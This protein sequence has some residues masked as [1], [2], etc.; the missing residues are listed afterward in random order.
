M[1]NCSSNITKPVC[2]S[3]IFQRKCS[4]H[5]VQRSQTDW[6]GLS[7]TA[8]R[9]P[10]VSCAPLDSSQHRDPNQEHFLVFASYLDELILMFFFIINQL[11][12]KMNQ[13]ELPRLSKLH[14]K[15]L[16]QIFSSLSNIQTDGWLFEFVWP[17]NTQQLKGEPHFPWCP[18]ESGHSNKGWNREGPNLP[19]QA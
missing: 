8:G 1:S 13:S 6:V 15:C 9:V 16:A 2:R 4:P 12:I 18:N 10:E 14:V 17:I 19:I 5:Q 11:G 3:L 7:S